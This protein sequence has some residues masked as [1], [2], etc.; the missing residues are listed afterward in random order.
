MN[1]FLNMDC[2]QGTLKLFENNINVDLIIL[3]PPYF[4]TNIKELGDNNWKTVED[5]LL[6]FKNILNL[7]ISLLNDNG[8]FYIF[9]NDLSLMTD[10]L[11]WLKHDKDCTLRNHIK[12][13]KFPTHDNFSRCIKT[14]GKNRR[15]GQTFVE[16]IYYITK[17]GDYFETPFS[18]IMKYNMQVHNLSMKDLSRLQL[19]KNGKVTGWVSNKLKGTQIPTEEQW[20]KLCEL[21]GINNEYN[22]LVNEYNNQRYKFNQKYQDFSCSI[23]QQKE[24]LKP[25]SEIWEYKKDEVNWFYTTKPLK[26]LKNIIQISTNEGDLVLD[27]FSGSGTTGIV[28]NL[29]KRNS[30]CIEKNTEYYDNS[31]IRYRQFCGEPDEF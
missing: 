11:Y 28:C 14:Y 23:E 3:D 10:I 7:C 1:T 21:F 22:K 12:W 29:L 30:I 4:S 20:I 2:E 6:W 19:S 17:Q 31:I 18:K 8:S 9:H 24:L 16:D 5:Y 15:Y 25:F 26:M 13:N 27:P